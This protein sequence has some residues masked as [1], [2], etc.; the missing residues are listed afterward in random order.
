MQDNQ[1]IEEIGK[2]A[3]ELKHNIEKFSKKI[4]VDLDELHRL[5]QPPKPITSVADFAFIRGILDSLNAQ[6]KTIDQLESAFMTGCREI[7][8]EG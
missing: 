7:A 8:K 4:F 3:N 5:I 6:V 1:H 2:K